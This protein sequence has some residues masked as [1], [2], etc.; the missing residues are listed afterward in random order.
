MGQ[1]RGRSHGLLVYWRLSR[2]SRIGEPMGTVQRAAVAGDMRLELSSG[3]RRTPSQP[4][5][6]MIVLAPNDDLLVGLEGQ[7]FPSELERS[8]H[9][10]LDRTLGVGGMGAVFFAI[11]SA[12]DGESPVVMKVLIP[13]VVSGSADAAALL[14]AKEAVA[15]G[16][17]N[18][19]VPPTPFVVRLIDTGGLRVTIGN[20]TLVLPWIVVEYVHGG[21]D[22]TT[23]EQRVTTS[24]RRTGQ[25]FDSARAALAVECLSSGLSA[26]HEVGVVHRDLKPGNVLC[27]GSGDSEIFKIADFGIARPAGMVGTFGGGAIGTPG[28]A[29]PEQF[30]ND[31][32]QIGP[33][34]DVFTFACVIYYLLTGE[35]Y[36]DVQ[37]PGEGVVAARD[38]ARRRLMDA[39]GLSS[40]LR[41]RESACAAIDA[42]PAERSDARA[43]DPPVTAS[44]ESSASRRATLQHSIRRRRDRGAGLEVDREAHPGRR[45]QREVRGVGERWAML[46]R[47][48]QWAGVLERHGLAVRDWKGIA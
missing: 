34:C 6:T 22:G 15:L 23:L 24:V 9:Y 36:F 41:D 17:L 1:T 2:S 32:N 18:E 5:T 46:G 8:I 28:Y 4:P 26:I 42:A 10:R 38:P 11:R 3:R 29:P 30:G 25:A 47:Y 39:H 37:S 16:R 35:D 20:A 7:S 14:I 44:V 13:A 19:R 48:Q 33:W 31:A 40:D 27:C 45:P 12:P 43:T 21:P